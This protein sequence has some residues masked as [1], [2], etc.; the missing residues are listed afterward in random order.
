MGDKYRC[1]AV[2]DGRRCLKLAGHDGICNIAPDP[3]EPAT[4]PEPAAPCDHTEPGTCDGCRA[5]ER[6]VVARRTAPAPEDDAERSDDEERSAE[7]RA[8]LS[9]RGAA[10]R[11]PGGRQGAAHARRQRARSAPLQ[12]A[13]RRRCRRS[14]HEGGVEVS[15]ELAAALDGRTVAGLAIDA[16]RSIRHAVTGRIILRGLVLTARA[17]MPRA[18]SSAT[19]ARD[20]LVLRA[21]ALRV[22]AVARRDFAQA[23]L[24]VTLIAMANG[25]RTALDVIAASAALGRAQRRVDAVLDFVDD[26]RAF[27]GLDDSE[28]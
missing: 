5:I 13:Q 25:N 26:V 21:E 14:H 9:R 2:H 18:S 16:G 22:A 23:R 15:A 7:E 24:S 20:V 11:R 12:R 1:E 19:A 28:L 8:R 4:P 3:F 27:L 6:E 17:L 10:R